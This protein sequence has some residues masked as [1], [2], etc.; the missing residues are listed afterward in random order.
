MELNVIDSGISRRI[1]VHDWFLDDDNIVP[2]VVEQYLR[3][4]LPCGLKDCKSCTLPKYSA[5][6]PRNEALAKVAPFK[7]T[8]IMDIPTMTRFVD[9]LEDDHIDN[10]VIIQTHWEH[11]ST[12]NP[13]IARKIDKILKGGEKHLAF[14][15][16]D[17]MEGTF[18]NPE[19][20]ESKE[21]ELHHKLIVAAGFLKKHWESL[22]I[23]PVIVVSTDEAKEAFLK[24]YEFVTTVGEYVDS[25]G[26]K[27]D[28][29]LR[30]QYL[31]KQED[32]GP[33]IYPEYLQLNDVDQGLAAGKYQKG[34][35]RVS[36]ENYLEA[37]VSFGVDYAESWFIQG[38]VSMNRACQGDIVVVELLPKDQWT[39]PEK[40]L[41]MREADEEMEEESAYMAE[42]AA[43]TA[44]PASKKAKKTPKAAAKPAADDEFQPLPTA[45]VVAVLKRNWRDYC[46]LMLPSFQADGTDGLFSAFDKSIPRIR[47]E[48]PLYQE[49]VGKIVV[50]AID[51]WPVD[52]HYPRGHLIQIIGNNGDQAAEEKMVLME[53]DIRYEPFNANVLACLPKMPWVPN[54]ESFRKDLTH[55]DICSVDPEGCTDIDDALHCVKNADGTYEVGV[56]IADVTHFLRPGTAMDNEASLRSTSVYLCGRR[57]DMLPDLLSS[58]LC[59]LRGGEVRYAFSV[60]WQLNEDSDVIKAEFHKSV[61]KSRAALTYQKAQE[62]IDDKKAKDSIS[63]SLRG[64]LHLSKKLKAKRFRDGALSLASSEIRFDIDPDTGTPLAVQEKKHLPTM[65]MVEEFMLLANVSVAKRIYEEYPDFAV[66]RRHPI[67]PKEQYEPLVRAADAL[68]FKIDPSTGKTLADSLDKAVDPSNPVVNRML[69]MLATRCMTQ[70]VYF[71]SSTMTPDKFLHFGLAA[72]LYT[73]FTSPIR[74]YADVMVHRLLASAIGADELHKEMLNKIWLI[75]QSDIMNYRHKK[76]QYASRASILLHTYLMIKGLENEVLEA[77]IVNI[78][79]NGIQVQIPK[80]GLESIIFFTKSFSKERRNEDFVDYAKLNIRPFQKVKVSVSMVEKNLR[81]RVEVKLIEP[82]VDCVSADADVAAY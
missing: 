80:Y 71:I 50:V 2:R 9:L 51:D 8:I 61:I 24:D 26:D 4:D 58:N 13:Q 15:M 20:F 48:D 45:R 69:R 77:F 37:T 74:R 64:L 10:A 32:T 7:H 53:H 30:I 36:P 12:T 66:L 19:D 57:I 52:S 46:G 40:V 38:R 82:K 16:N 44:E 62:M 79:K 75:K 1:L 60:V 54:P 5:L 42:T 21:E 31:L 70:A 39:L 55:L 17:M 3:T 76:A 73:H 27:A 25:M 35:F 49:I 43:E 59:S 68:G 63:E 72:P 47:V 14:L 33:S 56:H 67:P 18:V 81:R 29:A 41:R 11:L 34:A 65:S 28:L 23:K 78:R 6:E 22:D